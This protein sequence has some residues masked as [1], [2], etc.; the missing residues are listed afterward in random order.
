MYDITWAVILPSNSGK[1]RFRLESPYQTSYT[2]L[3]GDY[4]WEGGEAKVYLGICFTYM[5]TIKKST[6]HASVKRPTF[7]SKDVSVTS[8]RVKGSPQKW[9]SEPGS[10]RGHDLKNLVGDIT[11]PETNIAP[12]NGWLEYYFPIGKAHFQGVM[13]VSGRV[14]ITNI[15]SFFPEMPNG[16]RFFTNKTVLPKIGLLQFGTSTSST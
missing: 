8:S 10:K 13:L 9:R 16:A 5:T 3:A 4:C 11:L 2:N 15:S 14:V 6:I 1:W 7:L 12:K